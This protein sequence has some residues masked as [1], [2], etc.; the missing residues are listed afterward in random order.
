V[1][2]AKLDP[3]AQRE[4]AGM[5]ACDLWMRA[6]ETIDDPRKYS[7]RGNLEARRYLRRAIRRAPRFSL[8]YAKLSYTYLREYENGWGRAPQR[9]LNEALRLARQAVRLGR[10]QSDS[11]WCLAM[12]YSAK[13][14]WTNARREYARA[15]ALA[16]RNH[17]L[18][19]EEGEYLIQDGRGRRATTQVQRAIADATPYWYSETL[20]RALYMTRQYAQA[21]A[22]IG[23]MKTPSYEV[24]LVLAA[25]YARLGRMREARREIK[26]FLV[27]EP[28]WTL[29]DSAQTLWR[30]ASDKQHWLD[31]LRLAGLPP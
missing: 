20:A 16:P 18:L 3:V 8:A 2:G 7:R 6:V 29:R 13:G 4:A 5:D 21:I 28:N 25:C 17:R 27:H 1:S 12:V 23:Q 11:H 31:G 14:Q 22:T 9:A 10:R 26:R 19:A 24:S 30:R 15:R